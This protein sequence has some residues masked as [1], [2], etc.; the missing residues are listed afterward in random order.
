MVCVCV[1]ACLHVCACLRVWVGGR[2]GMG[3]R[4]GGIILGNNI[5]KLFFSCILMLLTQHMCIF[6]LVYWCFSYSTCAFVCVCVYI[7]LKKKK[8]NCRI[9]ITFLNI[10][11]L[12]FF[13]LNI[14]Y[15]GECCK[16][17]Q[18]CV[19][20]RM[21]LYKSDL[22]LLTFKLRNIYPYFI[23]VHTQYIPSYNQWAAP[24]HWSIFSPPNTLHMTAASA[25]KSQISLPP[26]CLSDSELE[27]DLFK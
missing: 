27:L 24:L 14:E 7:Y 25:A 2:V 4:R 10:L 20:Q 16:A 12:I 5:M 3:A 15:G 23:S 11:S 17:Q 13:S 26:G 21:A 22:L 8:K 19:D 6:F 1:C 9:C 18:V